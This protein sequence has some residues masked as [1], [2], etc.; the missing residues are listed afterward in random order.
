MYISMSILIYIYMQ[1]S[2]CLYKNVCMYECIEFVNIIRFVIN[3]YELK[4][5]DIYLPNFMFSIKLN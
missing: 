1:M 3:F 5:S 2:I 4:Y